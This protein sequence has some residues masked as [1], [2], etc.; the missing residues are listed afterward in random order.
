MSRLFPIASSSS[1]NCTYIGH[2]KDGILVDAGISCKGIAEALDLCAVDPKTLRGIFITHEHTDH[3]QGLRVFIKK[4]KIPVFA[5]SLTTDALMSEIP[6][7]EDYIHII[8]GD[9]CLGDMRIQ[10]FA[11]SHDCE[12]SSGYVVH[13]DDGRKCAVCTDLGV[14]SEEVHCAL[15]GCNAIL[16]E[17]NHDVALLQKGSYPPHLKKRIL[18]DKGHLSNVASAAELQR[19]V[20]SG[21]T[22]IVLGHLSRENNKPEIAR[23]CAVAALMDKQMVE[24]EDYTLYIAPPKNGKTIIF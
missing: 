5:S 2:G 6:E 15:T 19:L 1:G 3:I 13:L 20:E 21:T 22:R 12:G 17:S 18:S 10:R 9:V 23:S 14:V 8:D 16:F 11:T 24:D 4:F 7:I